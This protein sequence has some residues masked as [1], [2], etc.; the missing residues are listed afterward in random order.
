[1]FSRVALVVVRCTRCSSART[2][3][4]SESVRRLLVRV[5][6]QRCDGL[7]PPSPHQP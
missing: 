2:R 6:I 4:T 5:D 7:T 3:P 1:M